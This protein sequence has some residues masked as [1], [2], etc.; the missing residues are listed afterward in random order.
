MRATKIINAGR[1]LAQ[2][3]SVRV[4]VDY[5]ALDIRVTPQGQWMRILDDEMKPGGPVIWA[6]E[7]FEIRS[8]RISSNWAATIRRPEGG[9][10]S[11]YLAPRPWLRR[12]FWDDYF[13][14]PWEGAGATF[15]AAVAEMAAEEGLPPDGRVAGGIWR[16]R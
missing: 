8:P 4:G 2:H 9:G 6:V 1:E 13:D 15:D 5:L 11:L 7:M 16:G 14:R 10:W 3:P 12:G